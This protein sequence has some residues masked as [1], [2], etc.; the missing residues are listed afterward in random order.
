M[1]CLFPHRL[2]LKDY[3]INNILARMAYDTQQTPYRSSQVR[4]VYASSSESFG[5]HTQKALLEPGEP[6]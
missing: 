1:H 2:K 5:Q 4:H 6:R 3:K